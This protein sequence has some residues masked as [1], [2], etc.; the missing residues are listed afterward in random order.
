MVPLPPLQLSSTVTSSLDS[1][2]SSFGVSPGDWNVNIA[3]TGPA[4][5]AATGGMSAAVWVALAL[6]VVLFLKK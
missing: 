2:G 6:A 4:L 3:G 1:R 5:Q